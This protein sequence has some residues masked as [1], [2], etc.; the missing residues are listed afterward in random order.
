MYSIQLHRCGYI[1]KNTSLD[2]FRKTTRDGE[3]FLEGSQ[4]AKYSGDPGLALQN[5][6]RAAEALSSP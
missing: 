4:T 1:H 2:D 3:G 5:G 6:F